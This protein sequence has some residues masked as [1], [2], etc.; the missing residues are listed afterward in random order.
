MCGLSWRRGCSQEGEPTGF[1]ILWVLR[2]EL[3]GK[4]SV[5]DFNRIF[6]SFQGV[7]FQGWGSSL[8]GWCQGRGYYTVQLVLRS[9]VA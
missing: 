5:E 9:A 4:V 7:C 3:L 8:I 1:S 6:S 2:V